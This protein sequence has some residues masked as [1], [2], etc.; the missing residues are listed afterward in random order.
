MP[1]GS[2]FLDGHH[3]LVETGFVA[4]GMSYVRFR[5]VFDALGPRID[6]MSHQGKWVSLQD[7]SHLQLAPEDLPYL[8][9]TD[10]QTL[11]AL[12]EQGVR[13]MDPAATFSYACLPR[14]PVQ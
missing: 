12:F 4:H 8:Q 1:T 6:I 13:Q 14:T 2:P 3:L 11:I 5:F 10:L 7:Y 9:Y